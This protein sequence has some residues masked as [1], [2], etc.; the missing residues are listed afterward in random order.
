MGANCCHNKQEELEKKSVEHRNVLWIVLII[1]AI[2]FFVEMYFGILAESVAVIGD[3]LDMLG[4]SI[5]YASSIAVVGMVIGKKARVAELKGW[6]M[7]IMGISILVQ[8]GYRIL[9]PGIPDHGIM[10]AV[11]IV[12]LVANLTCLY[13][14]TRHRDDDINMK[15]VWLCSRNDI[16]A[17]CSVLAA[18][19]LVLWSGT[20]WPDLIVGLGLTVLFTRSAFLVITES[21]KIA[22][23]GTEDIQPELASVR[24]K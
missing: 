13:L 14:L 7:L 3:S 9:H 10:T 24:E 22:A 20:F 8:A 2:M 5:T 4:D 21:R 18:A 6:I 11:G 19:G 1:N 23:N 12:A 15:S 17:N 16:I